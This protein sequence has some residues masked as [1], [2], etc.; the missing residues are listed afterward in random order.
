MQALKNGLK[1]RTAGIGI[2][3]ALMYAGSSLSAKVSMFGSYTVKKHS[4]CCYHTLRQ[5]AV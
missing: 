1:K 4:I 3:Q 5:A 2:F